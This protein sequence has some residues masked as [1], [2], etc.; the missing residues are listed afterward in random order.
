MAQGWRNS[1]KVRVRVALALHEQM[2]HS[3][4]IYFFTTNYLLKIKK[5]NKE[6]FEKL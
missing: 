6:K 3:K 5:L 1:V 4:V 2:D